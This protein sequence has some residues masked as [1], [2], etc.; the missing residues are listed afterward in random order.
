MTA[1][2]RYLRSIVDHYRSYADFVEQQ[3][4]TQ[5]SSAVSSGR[6]SVLST[7]RH[8]ATV[9]GGVRG[10]G[11]TTP[12]ATTPAPAGRALLGDGRSVD[13]GAVATAVAARKK[14]KTVCVSVYWF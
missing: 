10:G 14:E 5:Y 1:M 12:F 8:T 9:G 11:V 3:R 13:S 7:P 6:L 4:L 2:F